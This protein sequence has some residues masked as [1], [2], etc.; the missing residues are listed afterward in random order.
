MSSIRIS[1]RS[2]DELNHVYK[3]LKKE[4][5]ADGSIKLNQLSMDYELCLS[6]NELDGSLKAICDKVIETDELMDVE[7]IFAQ[8]TNA[9]LNEAL[10]AE[11]PPVALRGLS[12][13]WQNL[14]DEKQHACFEYLCDQKAIIPPE[15]K[16]APEAIHKD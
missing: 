13:I 14:S 3:K 2:I 9:K 15:Q 16:A 5:K 7:S 12:T 4:Y 8:F 6:K 11:R 10:M 1:A